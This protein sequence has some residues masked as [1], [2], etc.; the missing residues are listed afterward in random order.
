[1][2]SKSKKNIQML[3]FNHKDE[4]GDMN[5]GCLFSELFQVQSTYLLVQS[6]ISIARGLPWCWVRENGERLGCCSALEQ[7][8]TH[9][10]FINSVRELT[11]SMHANQSQVKRFR[12]M[13]CDCVMSPTIF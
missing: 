9:P 8:N 2:N 5:L 10:D 1:M 11:T 13:I 3:F 7:C 6:I 4:M 12:D